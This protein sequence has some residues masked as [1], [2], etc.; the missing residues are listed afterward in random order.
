[1]GKQAE[2]AR[3]L[4]ETKATLMIQNASLASVR[5][6][7]QTEQNKERVAAG[8]LNELRERNTAVHQSRVKDEQSEEARVAAAN[9]KVN[10]ALTTKQQV[11]TAKRRITELQREASAVVKQTT[12]STEAMHSINADEIAA[13]EQTSSLD[14]STVAEAPKVAEASDKAAQTDSTVQQQA[15]DAQQVQI[16]AARDTSDQAARVSELTEEEAKELAVTNEASQMVDQTAAAK[17]TAATKVKKFE[18]E[19]QG[20]AQAI[21]AKEE[22]VTEVKQELQTKELQTVESNDAYTVSQL[23]VEDL[24]TRDVALNTQMKHIHAETEARKETLEKARTNGERA[25]KL[26]QT[27]FASKK[28]PLSL[29]SNY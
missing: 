28:T 12:A 7:V 4:T 21:F 5:S 24:K 29:H 18:T 9:Q 20:S 16:E 10:A 27:E 3:E 25:T 6:E 19:Q 26:I 2:V 11:Q 17:S 1:M 15:S 23:K 22:T 14:G 8:A 13:V